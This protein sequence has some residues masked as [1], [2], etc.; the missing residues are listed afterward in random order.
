MGGLASL[1][2]LSSGLEVFNTTSGYKAGE[3]MSLEYTGMGASETRSYDSAGKG[4]YFQ[5][6][7]DFPGAVWTCIESGPIRTVFSTAPVATNHSTVTLQLTVYSQVPKIDFS[8]SLTDWDSAFGVANRVVFPLA[9]SAR[10]VSY[11]VPF[12]V[13]RVGWDEAE[14]GEDDVWLTN[15]GPAV[16]PFERGWAMHPREISD[17]MAAEGGVGEE[18]LLISS[19]VGTFD[20]VRWGC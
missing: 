13:V 4:A 10:N 14:N 8:V 12:G 1:V 6:L 2:D 11:A 18:G 15:P 20:W 5:R 16:P 19:S 7:S 17:W 9:T 3:W